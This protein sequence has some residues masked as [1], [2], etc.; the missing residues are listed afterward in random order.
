MLTP[1]IA[2]L[3]VVV[4]ASLAAPAMAQTEPQQAP[5]GY[6]PSPPGPPPNYPPAPAGAPT[7]YPAQPGSYQYVPTT[8]GVRPGVQTHDGFYLNLQLGPGY[9]RMSATSGGADVTVSGGGVE[10]SV[11]LGGVVAPNL[12]IFGQIVGNSAIDPKVEISGLG[13][14][15]GNG[16][17]TVSGLGAG[18]TYFVMPANVYLSGSLLATQLAIS[19]ENGDD[20]GKSDLGFGINLSVGKEWWV[21]DQWGLGGALQFMAARM[22]DKGSVAG[23]KPTWTSVAFALALSATF[24]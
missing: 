9:S 8:V 14:G 19:D 17:A 18:L 2:L 6:P 11:A 5:P 24:N 4:L 22:E 7:Y 23:S 15:T 13:S 10:L 20:V 1:R 12:V 3:S 16:S 21:S